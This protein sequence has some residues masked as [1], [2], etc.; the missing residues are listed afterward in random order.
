MVC[1]TIDKTKVISCSLLTGKDGA[2]AMIKR[3][4]AVAMAFVG[5]S[6]GAG[7][8]S[9]Q[10]ILQ[11]FVAFGVKGLGGAIFAG[12]GMCL[13][14]LVMV[15]LGS[16][17]QADEHTAV[18]DE[19]APTPLAKLFDAAVVLT[20]FSIGFVMFAGAGSNLQQQFGLPT[21][22]GAV[23]LLVIVLVLGRLDVDKVSNVIGAISPLIVVFIL[24]AFV[25]SIRHAPAD[26]HSLV[27]ETEKIHTTLPNFWI[28]A[29]NYLGFSLMV[30]V[31]MSIVIGGYYLNPRTAGLGG[32][33]GGFIFGLLLVCSAIALFIQAATVRHDDLP[34]L[35]LVGKM[36]PWMGTAMAVVIYLMI[37][38]SAIG[39]FYALGRRFTS[40]KPE[41]FYRV[42]VTLT[43]TGF[44]ISFFGFRTLVTYVYP[45]LG[46]V[47]VALSILMV[48]S[49]IKDRAL[50]KEETERRIRVRDLITLKLDPEKPFTRR[51][52]RDL[53]KEIADSNIDDHELRETMEGKI[54]KLLED[55]TEPH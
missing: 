30:P 19:I 45:I 20:I 10:E 52:R 32:L 31:S 53:A 15:Q 33:L 39:M 29:L 43:V 36:H 51:D 54:G 46:Y 50:I 13:V 37:L 22:V 44:V 48:L 12:L 17:H 1:H 11:F 35:T 41:R 23:V 2:F 40:D 49:W 5:L 4:L 9:G 27:P 7:F 24:V 25:Y 18:L 26:W 38:N 47:G 55:G 42:F 14:G 21:W 6:V 28:A 3:V 34:M 16:Y 8:A